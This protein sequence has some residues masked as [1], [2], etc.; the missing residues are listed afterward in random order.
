MYRNHRVREAGLLGAE[1]D[2]VVADGGELRLE[3]EAAVLADLDGILHI[4][5]IHHQRRGGIDRAG[6]G[7]G[8]LRGSLRDVQ[9]GLQRNV[10]RLSVEHDVPAGL[11]VV[12]RLHEDGDA[13]VAVADAY[14]GGQKPGVV[15]DVGHVLA[16]NQNS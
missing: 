11:P 14:V 15:H 16:V 6:D 1:G 8:V 7:H 10:L 12:R 2:G 5:G 13:V 3:G 9:A 4:L